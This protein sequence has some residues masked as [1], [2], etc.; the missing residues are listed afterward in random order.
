[1][2]RFSCSSHP[3]SIHHGEYWGNMKHGKG[4][5]LRPDGSTYTGTWEGGIVL[6][7]GTVTFPVGDPAKKDGLPKQVRRCNTQQPA[8]RR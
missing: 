2:P 7:T 6:G 8:A 5:L 4:K 3:C 1:M